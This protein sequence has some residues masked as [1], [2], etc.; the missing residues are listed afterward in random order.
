MKEY[1]SVLIVDDE[2]TMALALQVRFRAAGFFVS[3]TAST[4]DE[5]VSLAIK[6]HPD[7]IIMDIRLSGEGDGIDAA[8][9]INEKMQTQIIFI[10]GYSEGEVKTRAMKLHPLAYLLKPFAVSELISIIQQSYGSMC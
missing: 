3:G 6:N 4:M 2:A 10:S 5:A 7:F 8:E 1:P 9:Q